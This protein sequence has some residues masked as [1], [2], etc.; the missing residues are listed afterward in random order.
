MDRRWR[1]W[2]VAS[3]PDISGIRRSISTIAGRCS[4]ACSTASRPVS[5]SPTSTRSGA[6][7]DEAAQAVAVDGV[8]VGD[9]DADL[10]GHG[11]AAT[12]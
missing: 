6:R 1:I 7:S 9:Q 11:Q 3:I 2:R 4:A 8:V 12:G 5:A 10:V